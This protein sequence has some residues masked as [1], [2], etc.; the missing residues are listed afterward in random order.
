M[1]YPE[2]Y[3]WEPPDPPV[4]DSVQLRCVNPECEM[5]SEHVLWAEKWHPETYFEYQGEYPHGGV[6]W[7]YTDDSHDCPECHTPGEEV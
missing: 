4:D 2:H 7:V 5:Y 3:E 1:S 6:V